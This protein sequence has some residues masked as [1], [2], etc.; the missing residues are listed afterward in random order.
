MLHSLYDWT[1]D[2][3]ASPHAV[4][5]LAAISFV[6][7]SVFPLP[8]DLLLIPMIL[9]AP[10]QAWF[11]ATVATASSV[12]GGFLGYAI[13]RFAF[14][15]I[16]M[17]V[18]RF[19]GVVD[20]Y[21]ALEGLYRRWGVWIIILKGM[22]PIPYKVVTIASGAFHFDVT[23]FGLA[24]VVCRAIRFYLLAA[25]IWKFGEPIK[26]FIEGRLALVSTVFAVLLVGGF[27]ALRYLFPRKPGKEVA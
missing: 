23:R 8:P 4:W 3:A 1:L 16:G 18:L 2:L 6:E 11:L 7:S 20:K 24:S 25:L 5:A 21:Q 17:R 12:A 22:T 14:D 26:E 15:T 13:G 10:D 27:V 9:A 19:Y